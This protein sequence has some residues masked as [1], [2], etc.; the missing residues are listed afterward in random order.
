MLT[1]FYYQ[2]FNYHF[3][4]YKNKLE[5]KYS[6]E[7][8]LIKFKNDFQKY[9]KTNGL[10]SLSKNYNY[11]FEISFKV[12]C[13]DSLVKKEKR[14]SKA[15]FCVTDNGHTRQHSHII[16]RKG[17]KY[18]HPLPIPVDEIF[19]ELRQGQNIVKTSANL[20]KY[21]ELE[22]SSHQ[23]PPL[24]TII[25][26]EYIKNNFPNGIS[27]FIEHLTQ[28]KILLPNN[29]NYLVIGDMMVVVHPNRVLENDYEVNSII[30]EI[31]RGYQEGTIANI[32]EG[33]FYWLIHSTW[34]FYFWYS[35]N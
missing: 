31:N 8:K 15:L 11:Y 20:H 29:A 30:S 26:I 34:T 4:Y 32:N 12:Y 28:L 22:G 6:K 24:F 14:N 10:E 19:L 35:E 17:S 5:T 7:L 25:P 21:M 23:K 3:L 16:P 9:L 18:L 2:Y 33:E 1:N 13:E 27:G